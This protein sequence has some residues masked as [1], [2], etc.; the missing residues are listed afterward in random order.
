MVKQLIIFK[1]IDRCID[2]CFDNIIRDVYASAVD[3][4]FKSKIPFERSFI[5]E[6]LTKHE[7]RALQRR[8]LVDFPSLWI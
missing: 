4:K 3:I 7:E 1:I 6:R 8:G 5:A 2:L